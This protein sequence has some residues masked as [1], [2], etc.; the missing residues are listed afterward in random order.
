MMKLGA[1]LLLSSQFGHTIV[2]IRYQWV[3]FVFIL[4]DSNDKP[5]SNVTICFIK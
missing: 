4:N 2:R 1:H 3:D 5:N